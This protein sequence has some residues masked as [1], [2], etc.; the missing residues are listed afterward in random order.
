M[1]EKRGITLI[2]LVVTIIILVIL[3][4]VTINLVF[5]NDGIIERSKEARFKTHFSEIQEKV[6]L[7]VA[8]KDTDAII[9]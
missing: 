2:A 4:G 6:S 7:Y 9:N 5:G 3:A 8:D 1:R